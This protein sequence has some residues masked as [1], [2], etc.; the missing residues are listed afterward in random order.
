MKSWKM[1]WATL[2]ARAREVWIAYTY[3][4]GK[5]EDKKELE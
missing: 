1:K 3:L 4:L 2:V 5:S